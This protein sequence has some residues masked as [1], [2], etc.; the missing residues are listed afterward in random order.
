MNRIDQLFRNK[1]QNILSI[2]F[3]AGYP[4][5]ND[6]LPTL[7]A[8]QKSG[9]DLVE[10]GI[11][12]SDPMADGPVIQESS[13]IA[14]KNGMSIEVLFEQLKNVRS[15][16]TIPLIFMGYL[17]PI[18]QYG[19]EKFCQKCVETGIDGLII[20]DLPYDIPD[21]RLA[22]ATKSHN[23]RLIRLITPETSP[24]R[25]RM[26]DAHTSGFLYL[27]STAATTGTRREFPKE[28]TDYFQQVAQMS[29]TNPLLVGFGISN[30]ETY[31]AACQYTSGGIIGSHFIR[32][33][34][35]EKHPS[36]AIKQLLADI[37]R[38]KS[39]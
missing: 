39:E 10:I 20:P 23:L 31:Q 35:S 33:L 37:G 18:M 21:T 14:L 30:R 16:I 27:V 34:A 6:T 38:E 19:I 29:L 4:E 32:L 13:S 17:N 1:R 28:T 12:F 5:L 15:E 25:I 26:I 7:Q 22:D 11:P 36:R 24:E 9:V 3:T 8:L 2:Y